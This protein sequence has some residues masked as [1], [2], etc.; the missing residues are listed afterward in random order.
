MASFNPIQVIHAKKKQEI[1]TFRF[2]ERCHYS[3]CHV[4]LMAVNSKASRVQ[5]FCYSQGPFLLASKPFFQRSCQR[6]WQSITPSFPVMLIG[7][8]WACQIFGGICQ[9]HLV[10]LSTQVNKEFSLKDTWYLWGNFGTFCP[11]IQLINHLSEIQKKGLL[12]KMTF[13][14]ILKRWL[15]SWITG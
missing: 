11:V 9:I 6:I 5:P 3:P 8:W 10:N 7:A 4:L 2:L 1:Q 12:P 14:R 15:I 13:C